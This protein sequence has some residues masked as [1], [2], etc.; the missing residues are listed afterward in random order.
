MSRSAIDWSPDALRLRAHLLG[1]FRV[2]LGVNEAGPWQRP[3]AK[4]LCEFVLLSP[5]RLVAKEAAMEALWPQLSPAGA[6]RALSQALSYARAALSA[7]GDEAAGLLNADRANIWAYSGGRLEVDLDLH[8]DALHRALGTGP[9]AER[10]NLLVAALGEE[11]VLLADEPYAEWVL[12]PRERL[13]KLRQDARL[14]LA[15]DR[16]RGMGVSGRAGV[17]E[18]WETC[19][20]HDPANEEVANALVRAY[21][22]QA[23]HSLVE[24]AYRRCVAALDGLGLRP[25][26]ALEQAYLAA[27]TPAPPAQGRLWAPPV[28]HARAEERRL[29]SV[30]IAALG[31]PGSTGPEMPEEAQRQL[32]C[33]ALASII[34]HIE[35]LGGT[36]TSVTGGGLVALFGAPV[37]HE[38]DPER[39]LLAALR[40]VRSVNREPGQL[41]MR[42][43]VETGPAV[44]GP[45]PGEGNYGA[46][47]DVVGVAA[48]L[49]AIAAP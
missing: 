34:G 29:V 13:E 22:A 26:P 45:L 10:D 36:I 35:E 43:G 25:S 11:S 38:N 12:G 20:A 47:G 33:S 44:V 32:V 5:G 28:G 2:T 14:A 4:R 37:S 24:L 18:A 19:A 31:Y 49:E 6:A 9:G 23:R 30:L 41:T 39:A 7:A 8:I 3:P 40:A 1:M 48:A 15:R 21:A 27:A 42:V 17:V 16:A 46:V